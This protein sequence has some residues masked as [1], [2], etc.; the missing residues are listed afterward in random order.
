MKSNNFE[1][2]LVLEQLSYSGLLWVIEL[3]RQGYPSRIS[4]V[5]LREMFFPHLPT[6]L[7]QLKPKTF[8]IE[9]L[10]AVA[11]KTED[12]QLGQTEVFFRLGKYVKIDALK[13]DPVYM[14]SIADNF[15]KH[16]IIILKWK[17]LV[18]KL[19]SVKKCESSII[20]CT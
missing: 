20:I 14:K 5:E 17:T 2:Q 6:E 13:E 8:C 12:Y 9:I 3:M 7:N 19:I 1:G 16:R 10:R 18:F 11:F 15:I 4:M